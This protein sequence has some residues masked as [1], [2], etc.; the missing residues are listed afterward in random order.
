M[1]RVAVPFC[2]SEPAR[3]ERPCNA[4]IQTARVIDDD[5]GL[6]ANQLPAGT[7]D[8]LWRASLLAL[9]Y[10]VA[11]SLTIAFCL[12]HRIHRVWG[13]LQPSASK[14]ARHRDLCLSERAVGFGVKLRHLASLPTTTPESAGLCALALI[15]IV[16]MS[17]PIQRPGLATRS[18]ISAS[19]LQFRLHACKCA[20]FDMVAVR[21]RPSGLPG[22][23]PPG[24]LTCVQLPPLLV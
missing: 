4:G 12:T 11:P 24:S 14:L 2:R 6:T 20:I 16:S 15:S 8:P 17:L 19:T 3:D 7:T 10:E 1:A 5:G 22:L 13:C 9:G 18:G 23:I 21:G